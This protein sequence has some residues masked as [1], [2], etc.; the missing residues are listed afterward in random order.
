MAH[1]P[2]RAG[3]LA[4]AGTFALIAVPLQAQ[5]ASELPHTVITPSRTSQSIDDALPAT[6]II[7][8]ADID[9]WQAVD[10]VSMLSRETGVQFAQSGGRGAAASLFVRGAGSS[11]V[12]VLVDGVR[13]NAGTSGAAAVGGIALDS[14]DRIEI[15]R[16]NLSSLY[17]SSAV[18]G[19][20]QI[21]TRAGSERGLSVSAEAGQGRTLNGRA[22]AGTEAGGVRL[23]GTVGGGT[24]AA[25]SAINPARVI[26]SAF[27]PGVNPDIDGNEYLSASLGSTYRS[28]DTLLAING[29]LNR[30]RTDFDSTAD[31]PT[32]THVEKSQLAAANA[33][34]RTVVTPGWSTQLAVGASSDRSTNLVSDPL[35]FN[36]GSFNAGNLAITWSNEIELA[37]SV[38]GLAGAEYLGQ[39]GESTAYDATFS[40]L[41]Q[42]YTRS[43]GSAWAGLNSDLGPHQVQLNVRYDGYSDVGGATTGLAAYGYRLNHEWRAT[44][45]VSNAFRAPSFNDL[46]F[47][48]FGNPDL[49]PERSVSGELGLQYAGKDGTLRAAVYRTDTRD[50]IVYD[51]AS[52]RAQNIDAA[53]ATGFEL[54]GS[55]RSG[56]W[57][58]AGNGTVLRAVNDQTGERLLRR[59][60]WIVNASANLAPE[61]WSAGVEISVVGPRDD[62]DINTFQRV[63]LSSYTLVRLV[64]SWRVTPGLTLR[65]RLENAFDAVYE[66]VS[67]YNVMPRLAIV[68]ADLRF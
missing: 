68:G 24:T 64:G 19:V 36:N 18:G 31:G 55:W 42:R 7:T 28:G 41:T 10:L 9:R 16:G 57:V 60:P 25:F 51:P 52:S 2:A 3:R 40:G 1:R 43:V 38:R 14:I 67:G 47:P 17:G 27:A 37:P 61:T 56:P 32:A 23:G 20:V 6:S 29:W 66:T 53:R 48:Y 62:L 54:G 26:P 30:N 39:S 5:T 13:L 11:Q 8:R 34:A 45:Q 50:L 65:A 59:A 4:A 35:S 46:Y 63:Q 44:A 12:L 21:F 58:L 15:V 33:L 22:S 49:V